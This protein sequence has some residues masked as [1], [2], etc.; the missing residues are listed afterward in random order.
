M[1]S[2]QSVIRSRIWLNKRIRVLTAQTQL[3]KMVLISM[4]IFLFFLL[5]AMNR[6]YM[7]PLYTTPKGNFLLVLMFVNIMLG[8]WMMNKLAKIKY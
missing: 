1:D 4:P 8:S 3:S 5:N 7:E 2:L 6:E